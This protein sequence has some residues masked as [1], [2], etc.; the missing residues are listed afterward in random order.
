MHPLLA[1]AHTRVMG[2]VNVTPDSFSD[3]GRYLAREA[4][5][6]HGRWLAAAGADII[7]V[8]GE[9]TR[10]GAQ[11]IDPVEEC[12]R[13]LG[14]IEALAADGLAVS[15]DTIHA[16]TARA[17]V[18]A[19]ALI[20]NDVSGSLAD[21]AMPSVIAET[22]ALYVAQHLRGTPETMNSLAQYDDVV[23]EVSSELAE[24]VA[25]L[26]DAGVDP[27]RIILDPGI[28]FAKVGAQNWEL[29]AGLGELGELG[30]P[31]LVGVSRKR[32]LGELMPP[33]RAADPS[34]REAATTA[35]T[36]LLAQVPV[37]GVRVHD[38]AAA[39]DAIAAVEEL[40]AATVRR[41]AR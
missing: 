30:H 39:R 1:P 4:A 23:R 3:G 19:G 13:V 18:D 26:T 40:R 25:A 36:A 15:V 27:G 35:L 9:S 41:D 29:L 6:E 28:G 22:G 34:E 20:V 31:L 10:P 24:R 8:G 14:V 33:E 11:R 17:A 16:H 5:I 38:A 7:D 21:P 12:E 32:F 2:V 37:W